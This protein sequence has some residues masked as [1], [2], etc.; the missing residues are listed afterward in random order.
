MCSTALRRFLLDRNLLPKKPL[1][2]MVPVS[3]RG[4][5]DDAMN[6]QVSMIRVDLATEIDDPAA[7][8]KAIHASSEAAKAVVSELKPV[9]GVD[10]PI[11]GAPWLMTGLASLLGRSNFAGRAPAA[12]NVLISNVPGPSM[13]LYMA[14]ARMVHYYPVSIPYHGMALNITV[15]SYAGSL[16]FGLTACR[17]VLSQDESHELVEHLRAALQ[18]DRGAAAPGR[19]SRR[20]RRSEP[21]RSVARR[22]Q[23]AAPSRN[24]RVSQ[25]R[26]GKAAGKP[27]ARPTQTNTVAAAKTAR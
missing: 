1:I 23:P 27:A 15:Q 7:R 24:V 19:S 17:R 8:F 5:G 14:G 18:R 26:T 9:L 4:A 22:R 20:R 21:D 6:N 2:A 11:T 13:P 25:S 16:E 12:G 10:L 3:L